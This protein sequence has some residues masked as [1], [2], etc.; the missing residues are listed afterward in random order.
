[1]NERIREL[2]EQAGIDDAITPPQVHEPL[3]V[4]DKKPYG[5]FKRS[6]LIICCAGSG[7]GKSMFAAELLKLN[8]QKSG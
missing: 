8:N 5:G 2:A 7:V 1:M 4:M 6:E 3:I